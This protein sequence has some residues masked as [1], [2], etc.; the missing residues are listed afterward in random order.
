MKKLSIF[1]VIGI[2]LLMP[3][4]S[5]AAEEKF[6]EFA[7]DAG[8]PVEV[9]SGSVAV[10]EVT[11][12]NDFIDAVD[13]WYDNAGSSGS[14]T[15]A[16]LNA[17]NTVL[18]SKTVTAAH[19]TAFYTGQR[20]HVTFPDTVAIASGSQYKIRLTSSVPQLRLYGIQRIQFIEHNAPATIVDAVGGSTVDGEAQLVAFKFA[21]YEEIDTEGPIITNARGT[22]FGAD[23]VE[24]A[25]N[26]S[27]LVD[28]KLSYTPIGSGNVS[29]VDYVDNYSICFEGVFTCSMLIDVQRDTSYAY[30]LTVRDSWG[31]ESYV[32][33]TFDSWSSTAPT[34]SDDSP[35]ASTDPLVISNAHV[36]SVTYSSVYITWDTDR[37][38]N[39]AMVISLDPS[40]TQIVA[41]VTDGI[42]EL[43]HALSTGRGITAN[44]DYYATISSRDE[45]GVVASQVILFTSGSYT[46]PSEQTEDSPVTPVTAPA[47]TL[48]ASV[49]QG[50]G[51]AT[52]SWVP[53]A[54]EE[55]SGGYRI[56][57]I[58]AQ[59]NLVETRIVP[60]G[61]HSVDVTGLAGGEYRVIVY[62]D[63][64]G[65]LEK[66]A[67]PAAISVG[68]KAGPIDTY[69][70]IKRPIVY[71]PFALFVMLVG[72]LYW[73]SKRAKKEIGKR[74]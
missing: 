60:A 27:E 56:D 5:F 54:G 13:L 24:V 40:G 41:N 59:G 45:S 31:N 37:A 43:A 14:V 12:Y 20:L 70:L 18:T 61:T 71:V 69:E 53:P 15:V 3:S 4:A 67:A 49:S 34:P 16:L 26:A 36:A 42:Y 32:D 2:V 1:I 8:V 66:I 6:Y 74:G 21:L 33:G 51:S 52:I 9:P 50:Q 22:I 63:E 17:F 65:I 39:S 68:K 55:P 11:I 48:Q 47:T 35:E 64:A 44:A 10:Q 73:Y 7:T 38:A 72:G 29:T 62:G 46:T 58:D 19:A 30:R 23:T 25:Y 57:I 28:R